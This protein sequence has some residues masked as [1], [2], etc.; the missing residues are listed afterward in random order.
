MP[1]R[2]TGGEVADLITASVDSDPSTRTAAVRGLLEGNG[3]NKVLYRAAAC[4]RI[5]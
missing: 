3:D 4:R 2:K 5:I 1:S